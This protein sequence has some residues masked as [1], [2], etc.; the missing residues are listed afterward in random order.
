[1]NLVSLVTT[2]HYALPH[3]RKSP[4]GCGRVVFTSSGASTG[5]Y[6]GWSAYNASKAGANALMRTLA[7]EEKSIAAWSVRPGVVA[8]EVSICLHADSGHCSS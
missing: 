6:A 5:N 3:L 2:L 4:T 8:T 7:N 1:M